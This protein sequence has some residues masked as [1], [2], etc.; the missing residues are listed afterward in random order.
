MWSKLYEPP[1]VLPPK[2]AAVFRYA[3]GLLADL[4]EELEDDVDTRGGVFGKLSPGEKLAAILVVAKALLDSASKPPEVTA[5]LAATVSAIYD[6]LEVAINA[7]VDTSETTVRSMVLEALDEMD[8]WKSVG[9]RRLALKSRN[10]DEW[11][12][13]VEVLRGEVL[14]DEDFKMD[15]SSVLD[16]P[17]E[18]IAAL[19]AALHINPDYFVTPV[20]DP[21]PQRL[22]QIRKE[23]QSLLG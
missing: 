7:E 4:T 20:E 5:V 14:E 15:S 8:Y 12:G 16:A 13:L 3:A 1:L 18:K 17:P 21:S 23:L 6:H 9:Q 10:M 22:D 2:H 11:T 19:K